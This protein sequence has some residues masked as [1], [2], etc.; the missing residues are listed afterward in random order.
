M[1]K[2]KDSKKEF[3]IVYNSE[4]MSDNKVYDYVVSEEGVNL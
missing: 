4:N 3:T 1:I 2:F